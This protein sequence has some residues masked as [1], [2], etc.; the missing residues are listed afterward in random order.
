MFEML[1]INPALG[2]SLNS[3]DEKPGKTNVVVISD[4][5][6]RRRF[7]SDQKIIGRVITLG[8]DQVTIVGVMPAGVK[9]PLEADNLEFWTPLDSTTDLNK[10]RGANY[11]SVA[12]RL[13]AVCAC[14]DTIR[15]ACTAIQPVN[16]MVLSL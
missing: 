3:E 16:S 10:V 7:G 11:L 13:I 1:G 6:W 8:G 14:I 12:A 4:G 5:L 15:V 9:F 2:R